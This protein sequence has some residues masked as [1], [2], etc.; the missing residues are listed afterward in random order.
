MPRK[1]KKSPSPII[2]WS[3]F[4]RQ[5]LS[6]WLPTLIVSLTLAGM[7]YIAAWVPPPLL[8]DSPPKEDFRSYR[9]RPELARTLLRQP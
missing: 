9:G 2:K 1:R 4:R 6:R 7:R 3:A 5:L 8:P